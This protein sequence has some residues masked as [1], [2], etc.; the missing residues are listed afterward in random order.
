MRAARLRVVL[1]PG[2]AILTLA[3]G[4]V[5][6]AHLPKFV[7]VKNGATQYKVRT[8]GA[9]VGDVLRDGRV[10]VAANDRVYPAREALAR[11]G[12]TVT[13][14]RAFPVRLFADGH[15]RVLMTAAQ[16]VGEFLSESGVTVRP[17]DHVYPS[18][19]APLWSGATVRLV[20][21]ETRVVTIEE[22]VPFARI[23]Q[24]DPAMPRGRTRL[25]QQG[26]PG[27]KLR[28]IAVTTADGFVV[29]RQEIEAVI[30][31]PAQDR[32]VSVGTRR[33]I[34]SR[35]QFTGKEVLEMEA[36][37]YAPWHGK[38][39]DD[40][41][42]IGMKAGY[43]VVAVDPRIIPLRSVLFIEGYGRAVAGDT[44]GAIKGHRI[45]LGFPTAREAYRF[46]RRTVRVY[47]LS[48]P[49]AAR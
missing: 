13:V 25:I 18:A 30:A 22:R 9:T 15:P 2:V 43:G 23:S 3:L 7:L 1:L 14:R 16:S 31:R 12:M 44:G 39:V 37:G 34:A 47:I 36:T 41:T 19:D 6:H 42:A 4:A 48:S 35:G 46:G 40:I 28:R 11:T 33:V 8:F 45:D 26:R 49:T 32:I 21:V 17:S 20:R 27:I 10:A 5:A 29:K 24:V 38:G